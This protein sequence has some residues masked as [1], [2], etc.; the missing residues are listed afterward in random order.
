[1]K[2]QKIITHQVD[3]VV[4]SSSINF[5]T[6][7]EDCIDGHQ[8]RFFSFSPGYIWWKCSKCPY[9]EKTVDVPMSK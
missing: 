1:M 3:A 9:V 4:N 7:Q 8:L 5:S 6:V 2:K